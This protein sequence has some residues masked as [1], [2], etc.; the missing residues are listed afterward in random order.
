MN[1]RIKLKKYSSFGIY[2]K[3]INYIKAGESLDKIV[4]D[5]NK[6]FKTE[7][8]NIFYNNGIK[9]STIIGLSLV[10]KSSIIVE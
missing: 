6:S 4:E 10:K 8:E 5:L 7:I 9:E 3:D 1:N 2:Y